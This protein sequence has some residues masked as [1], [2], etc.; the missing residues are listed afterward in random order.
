MAWLDNEEAAASES[1]FSI[2]M[3]NLA[4]LPAGDSM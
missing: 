3:E 1:T 4:L 2:F